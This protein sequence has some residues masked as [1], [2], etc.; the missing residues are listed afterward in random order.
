MKSTQLFAILSLFLCLSLA[1]E[2]GDFHDDVITKK[3]VEATQRFAR[4]CNKRSTSTCILQS[5]V[6]E[7]P[8][9]YD[10]E[11]VRQDIT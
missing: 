9:Y 6:T 7:G 5:E 11:L 10:T 2:G 3:E 8:Y 1:H 4:A